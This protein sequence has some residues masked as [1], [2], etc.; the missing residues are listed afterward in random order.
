MI[1]GEAIK[2]KTNGLSKADRQR[3]AKLCRPKHPERQMN[4]HNEINRQKL[5]YY[6]PL[7]LNLNTDTKKHEVTEE[8]I[9][10]HSNS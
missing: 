6:I 5:N 3:K 9:N 7:N 2:R 8:K 10:R 4:K 1:G